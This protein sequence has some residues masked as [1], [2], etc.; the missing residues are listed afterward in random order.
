MAQPWTYSNGGRPR[1]E[2]PTLPSL[3]PQPFGGASPETTSYIPITQSLYG[4]MQQRAQQPVDRQTLNQYIYSMA[5]SLAPHVPRAAIDAMVGQESSGG[6]NM[7]SP[8]QRPSYGPDVM[9]GPGHLSTRTARN[10]GYTGSLEDLADYRNNVPVWMKTLEQNYNNY[11]LQGMLRR[12]YGTG[13]A[14]PGYPTTDEYVKQV[15]ARMGQKFDPMQ[16][17]YSTLEDMGGGLAPAIADV[18]RTAQ[19]GM[20]GNLDDANAD[21]KAKRQA[22]ADAWNKP[23]AP[24]EVSRFAKLP[25]PYQPSSNQEFFSGLLGNIGSAISGNPAYAAQANARS[26]DARLAARDVEQRNALLSREEE[27]AAMSRRQSLALDDLEG[28]QRRQTALQGV[29]DAWPHLTA[30]AEINGLTTEERVLARLGMG[31]DANGNLVRRTGTSASGQPKS[32][33]DEKDWQSNLADTEKS[34]R[35]WSSNQQNAALLQRAMKDRD[36]AAQAQVARAL[37]GHT[38]AYMHAIAARRAGDDFGSVYNRLRGTDMLPN[39]FPIDQ[40]QKMSY[41]TELATDYA[42]DGD[43]NAAQYLMQVG[44]RKLSDSLGVQVPKTS[45]ELK[46]ARVPKNKALNALGEILPNIQKA[47]KPGGAL[48]TEGDYLDSAGQ[49]RDAMLNLFTNDQYDIH[50]LGGDLLR[51]ITGHPSYERMID[52]WTQE[53]N[54]SNPKVSGPARMRLMHVMQQQQEMLQGGDR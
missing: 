35:D 50:N 46:A 7:I 38:Q 6:A 23:L 37:Q 26:M 53:A 43:S 15:M 8:I 31:Y 41:I 11:G 52:Q 10:Y 17:A 2:Q 16:A 14:P 21:V 47:L 18:M 12:Q 30:Q 36:P 19:G 28:A 1:M 45:K 4:L 32:E 22:L 42:R 13:Q 33:M 40:Q 3:T 25:M 54:S 24:E 49:M 29:M 39:G 44:A 34:L 20:Q 48:E 5:D 9:L 51:A 27:Q